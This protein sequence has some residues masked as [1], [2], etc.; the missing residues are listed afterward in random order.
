M[1]DKSEYPWFATWDLAF[2]CVAMARIDP[3]FAKQQVI[4]LGREWFMHP[5][6]QLP[7]YEFAFSDT[8]PP[9]HALRPACYQLSP[10]PGYGRDL[11]FEAAFQKSLVNFTWWVNR[12][13]LDGNNLFAGGFLGLD[14]I[15]IFDRSKPI[16]GAAFGAG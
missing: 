7:A 9:L 8:N 2:H 1:P 16:P 10:D 15:G 5:N 12:E 13:D 14:N 3:D 11:A 6:G 4:L